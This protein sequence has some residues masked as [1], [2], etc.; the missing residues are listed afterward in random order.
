MRVAPVG[1][2][3]QLALLHHVLEAVGQPGGGRIAVAAGAAGLLVVALDRLRQ[4]Q[5]GH[6]A[7]V[8]LVDAHAEGDRG[9][10]HDPVLAQEAG[11]V[12]G[13]RGGVHARVVAHRV[14]ALLH[15][16]GR[17]L[18][19]GG[20]R[21]AVDD[22]GV[23]LV[24]GP[25]QLQQL[26]ERVV[27]RGDPVLDVRPVEA[28]DEVPGLVEAEPGG[29][30]GVRG[31][32]GRRGQRD[33]RHLRPPLVQH[34]Q[35]EV[36]RP[37]V[38]APLGDAVRLVDRE[39][40][41]L[42]LVEEALR[43]LGAQ[44]L[45]GQVQQVQLA[46]EEELLDG[47]PLVEALGGVEEPGPHPERGERVYLVLHQRDQRRDHHA[48]AASDQR[49]DLVAERLA[50]AGRHQHQCVAATRDMLDD[51]LL[52]AAEGVVPEDAVQHLQGIVGARGR[53]DRGHAGSLP[54]SDDTPGGLWKTPRPPSPR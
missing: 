37:E 19:H 44:P 54:T 31:R 18:L 41:H 29:D 39:E 42:A 27:L 48:G 7:H 24:L 28:G 6:E 22:A 49:R 52:L 9:H 20:P 5:V 21:E 14:D 15:Q 36:V 16:E 17:G 26:L 47:A 10:D 1:A 8:G 43:A 13:A 2:L 51:L 30:L 45:G 25:D 40:R 53:V 12:R 32:G 46:G 34:R 50:A 35:G 23:P 3:D 33:P 4:V 38:V 11:L